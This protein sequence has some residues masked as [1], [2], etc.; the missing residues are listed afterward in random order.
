[1]EE[2]LAPATLTVGGGQQFATIQAAVNAAAPGDT[3]SVYNGTYAE[4][5]TVTKN[6]LTLQEA[7]GQTATIKSPAAP[8]AGPSG[9]AILVDV[10][11]ATGVRIANFTIDG[12]NN[13]NLVTGVQVEGGGSAT[14]TGNTIQNVTGSALT[15]GSGGYGIRVGRSG[16]NLGPATTGTATITS[17]VVKG[18]GKDGIVVAAVGS[19]ASVEGNTVTGLGSKPNA[20]GTQ[21]G[22]EVSYGAT[23]TVG[24]T[25]K[26]TVSANQSKKGLFWSSGILVDGAGAGVRVGS[27]QGGNTLT[28]NDVGIWVLD[29]LN[30]TVS[31]NNVTAST[32]YGIAFDTDPSFDPATASARGVVGAN[33]NNNSSTNNTGDG[34]YIAYT[35]NSSFTNNTVN[36]NNGN[37]MTLYGKD[38]GNTI[39]QDS[40][41]NN[42]G[43]GVL[44]MRDDTAND[45]ANGYVYASLYGINSNTGNTISQN[46][47]KNN[48]GAYDALDQSTGSG[49]AGTANTWSGNT[50]GKKS[51]SGLK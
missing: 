43:Y 45:A 2:R 31:N 10:N 32:N 9:F 34:F 50:I 8:V 22:I 13:A 5:V 28:N 46:T 11:R 14:I 40:A 20:A 15:S 44:V 51:P 49:T 48:S 42:K 29:S 39:S 19:S 26:N 41:S 12:N 33:V 17:N 1:M 18:Y 23:A 37:G 3:V 6:N 21:N 30:P 25:S 35:A 24:I 27:S 4:Q 16:F 36:N 38:T 47:I 7:S